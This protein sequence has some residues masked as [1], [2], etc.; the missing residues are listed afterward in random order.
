MMCRSVAGSSSFGSQEMLFQ[1]AGPMSTLRVGLVLRI[2]A[3]AS[4]SNAFQ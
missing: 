3:R 1:N 2:T 4:T